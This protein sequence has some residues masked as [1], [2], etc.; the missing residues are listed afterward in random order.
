MTYEL[1]IGDR[2]FSSWSLRGWLLFNKFGI[3]V[4]VK[5]GRMY[6][7][8]FPALLEDFQPSRT[9]P[10]AKL[11][12]NIVWDSLAMA[13]M[14]YEIHPDAAMWPGDIAARGIARS[15][16]AE[17]HSGFT[18]LRSACS[19]D[20]RRH[21]PDFEANEDVMKDVARIERL[22]S[23]CREH[24]TDGEWLFGDYSIADV[25]YAP[26]AM[27]FATYGLAQSDFAKAYVE[28]HLKDKTFRRWRAMG[29]A[30]NFQQ[31][32]YDLDLVV[33]P[34]PGPTPWAA[35]PVDGADSINDKCPYSGDVIT[36]VL[37]LDGKR[38][39]FCNAFCR[40]KTVAD[41]EAWTDFVDMV[42]QG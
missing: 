10:A 26:V 12:G 41:A 14:L 23:L 35:K 3:P 27:R 34:W 9:V 24:A 1:A 40:D 31:T 2:L 39:G 8:A 5:H 42:N 17:M 32:V 15:V 4:S 11:N 19:M 28:S 7:D 30:E 21:Y 33:A 6:S 37:E 36:H 25:F 16:T 22:W 29:F 18:A 38:W 20:L 13:E